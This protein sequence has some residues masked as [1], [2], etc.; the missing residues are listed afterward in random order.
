[1]S[2]MFYDAHGF[3]EPVGNCDVSNITDM[4]C[5]FLDAHAFNQAVKNWDAPQVTKL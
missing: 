1:M 4:E 5:K 2:F 3:Y